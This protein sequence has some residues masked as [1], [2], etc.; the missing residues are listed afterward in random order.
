MGNRYGLPAIVSALPND[1]RNFL[2]R[3]REYIDSSTTGSG[4][5]IT[6]SAVEDMID[7]ITIPTGGPA[8][9][10][11]TPP[12]APTGLIVTGEVFTTIILEWDAPTLYG[13]L[14][15]TEVWR[16]GVDDRATAVLTGTANGTLYQDSV[17]P[18]SSYYYWIRFVSKADV[19][20]AYNQLAGVLGVTSEN[21]DRLFDVLTDVDAYP[22][23]APFHYQAEAILVDGVTIPPGTYIK[24]A[25]IRD[26][27]VTSAKVHDLSAD[28]IT[29]GTLTAGRKINVGGTI[30]IDGAGAITTYGPGGVNARDYS[31]GSRLKTYFFADISM[32]WAKCCTTI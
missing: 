14:A 21:P 26:L 7:D 29:T 22:S 19:T 16:S 32:E 1:V 23:N 4:Q 24:S 12:P 15:Y 10:D 28:K 17:D 11:T 18:L 8:T 2:Q 31:R 6:A 3:V 27:S 13:N 25:I 5:L 20:G 30:E 9:I